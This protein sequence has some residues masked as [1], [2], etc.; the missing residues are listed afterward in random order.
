MVRQILGFLCCRPTIFGRQDVELV[1]SNLFFL[2]EQE[3]EHKAVGTKWFSGRLLMA[4]PFG[5]EYRKLYRNTT[6]AEM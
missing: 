2:V 4:L 3:S 6:R 1:C 5:C